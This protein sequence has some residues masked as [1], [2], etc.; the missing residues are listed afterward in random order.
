[1]RILLNLNPI[2][3]TTFLTVNFPQDLFLIL[4]LAF[5]EGI[6]SIDNAIVLAIM[7]KPLPP[8]QQKKALTYGLVGS[9]VFRLIS[10]ALATHLMKWH[11]VKLLGGGYLI[12]IALSHLLRHGKDKTGEKSP[13]RVRSF[14]MTVMMIEVM[15][16]AFAVDS[17]LAAVALSPKFWI[18]F[19]GGML[20]VIF[21]RYAA[22][23]FVRLLGR[24]PGIESSAHILILQ[25]GKSV[26]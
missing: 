20:G 11:W 9:V 16:I 4:F 10:L 23:I 8:E 24:F 26:V 15:D 1:M 3:F 5:L 19:S 22:G 6:L 25:I 12:Y 2:Q 7:A 13:P 21:I 18:V 14:W 17:I